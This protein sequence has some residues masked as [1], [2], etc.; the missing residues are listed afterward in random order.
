MLTC[1]VFASE[2]EVILNIGTFF[3]IFSRIIKNRMT[4]AKVQDY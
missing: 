3:L 2:K 4:G 1:P